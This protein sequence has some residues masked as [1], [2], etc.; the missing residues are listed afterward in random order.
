[1]TNVVT[2]AGTLAAN[3]VPLEPFGSESV[4]SLRL[5]VDQP[6]FGHEAVSD[7][8]DFDLEVHGAAAELCMSGL[9]EGSRVTLI[10]R[11]IPVSAE[12][13]SQSVNFEV[14]FVNPLNAPS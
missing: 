12:E 1:M 8:W 7:P 2:L 5:V 4:C 13:G 3:P 6:G 10:G 9:R 11:L 14:C